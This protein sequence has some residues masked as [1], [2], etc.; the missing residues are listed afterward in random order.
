MSITIN[1]SDLVE[2][3]RGR[4]KQQSA[5]KQTQQESLPMLNINDPLEKALHKWHKATVWRDG[6]R[7]EFAKR[8]E[9]GYKTR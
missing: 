3:H 2:K 7:E 8:A 6:M 4:M 5:K 1:L 9:E